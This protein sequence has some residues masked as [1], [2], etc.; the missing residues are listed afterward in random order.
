MPSTLFSIFLGASIPFVINLGSF[1]IT[2]KIIIQSPEKAIS[3]NIA[4]FIIRLI[5]YAV[6]LILI[7]SLLEI[8]FTAFV[9]SFFMVFIF[10]QIGEALYFQRYFSSQKSDISK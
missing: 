1:I 5:L 8:I 7:A 6:A 2:R 3:A 9:L 4:A 10:L